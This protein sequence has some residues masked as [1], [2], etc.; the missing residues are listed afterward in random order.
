MLDI[1]DYHN[2]ETGKCDYECPEVEKEKK[3]SS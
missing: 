2:N 3:W 1:D